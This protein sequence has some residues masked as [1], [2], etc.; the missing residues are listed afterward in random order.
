[1]T[2]DFPNLERDLEIQVNEANMS[3]QNLSSKL[4]SPRTVILKVSLRQ[5]EHIKKSKRI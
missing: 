1:M 2:E 5:I 4:Y 3:P